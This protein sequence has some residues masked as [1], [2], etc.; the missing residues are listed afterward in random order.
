MLLH[1]IPVRDKHALKPARF[2]T[3]QHRLLLGQQTPG[4]IRLR[5]ARSLYALQK[6]LGLEGYITTCDAT[7]G[8]YIKSVLHR[9]A[10]EV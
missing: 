2:H 6:C 8:I 5:Q 9:T 10:K 4:I 3:P 1:R 7:F